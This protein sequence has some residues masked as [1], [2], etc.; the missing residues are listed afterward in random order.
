MST[1]LY[2]AKPNLLIRF[3][4]RIREAYYWKGNPDYEFFKKSPN[5]IGKFCYIRLGIISAETIVKNVGGRKK[6]FGVSISLSKKHIRCFARSPR[7][8]ACGKEGHYF[9]IEKCLDADTN[10]YHLNL[11][12]RTKNNTEIMLTIDHR[13]PISKGGSN[14]LRNLQTMCSPCNHSKSNKMIHVCRK[15]KP[16]YKKPD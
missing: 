13:I 4:N 11:Y 3:I 7:C 16:Q 9:A 15:P 6:F 5:H 12:S 14:R 1:R 10:K 2:R 8:I